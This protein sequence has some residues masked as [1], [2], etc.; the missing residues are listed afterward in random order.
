M[1]PLRGM[2]GIIHTEHEEN[3]KTFEDMEREAAIEE[4]LKKL[5]ANI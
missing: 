3:K 1:V 5:K 2:F 4:E